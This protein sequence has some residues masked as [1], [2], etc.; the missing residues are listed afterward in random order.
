MK[1]IE[2]KTSTGRMLM[3]LGIMVFMISIALMNEHVDLIDAWRVIG[4]TIS[5]LVL[6]FILK[7]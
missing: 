3:I 1:D 6:V 4:A 2:I 5:T 7:E